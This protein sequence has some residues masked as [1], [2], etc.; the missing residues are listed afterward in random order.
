MATKTTGLE[1][2]DFMDADAFWLEPDGVNE[3]WFDDLLIKRNGVI[4]ESPGI[5]DFNDA[6]EVVI[7]G[8]IVQSNNQDIDPIMFEAFFKKWRKQNSFGYLSVSVPK[9]KMDE[10]KELIKKLGGKYT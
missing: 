10:M 8:G 5:D 3:Y 6:D 4:E 1:L 2:K 9:D 7:L